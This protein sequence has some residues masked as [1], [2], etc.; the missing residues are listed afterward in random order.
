MRTY[1]GAIKEEDK[2][3]ASSRF[4]NIKVQQEELLYLAGITAICSGKEEKAIRDQYHGELLEAAE[5][6]ERSLEAGIGAIVL[7]ARTENFSG[8]KSF[9]L[10]E[11][12]YGITDAEG[13]AV[14]GDRV[15][16]TQVHIHQHFDEREISLAYSF[17][18]AIHFRIQ[19]Q[20]DNPVARFT[21]P[22]EIDHEPSL[23]RWYSFPLA[24]TVALTEC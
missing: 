8:L 3:A 7:Q 19:T 9:R 1:I 15:T 17:N 13:L 4:F 11:P 18:P 12:E 21:G 20:S 5:E 14:P 10:L 16:A 2:Q 24:D 22:G 6:L 23:G